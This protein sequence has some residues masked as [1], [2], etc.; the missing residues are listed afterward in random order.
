MRTDVAQN[1]AGASGIPEP[2]GSLGRVQAMR[3]ESHGVDHLANRAGA[4]EF[5][6]AYSGGVFQALAVLDRIDTLG[7]RLHVAHVRQ[8]RARENARFVGEEV[9]AVFHDAHAEWGAL[10]RNDG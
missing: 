7:L 10:H 4:H 8:L 2:V 3:T 9:L 1:A 6:S 5:T